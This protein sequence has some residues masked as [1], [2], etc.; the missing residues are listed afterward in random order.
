LGLVVT[1]AAALL[2]VA[3]LFFAAEAG[4]QATNT[5]PLL[6]KTVVID[7]GHEGSDLGATYTFNDGSRIAEREKALG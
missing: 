7:P 3:T 1:V 4:A 2:A 6:G 5:Q